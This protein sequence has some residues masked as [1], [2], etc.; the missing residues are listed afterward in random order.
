MG[1][2]VVALDCDCVNIRDINWLGKRLRH[3]VIAVANSSKRLPIFNGKIFGET[4]PT[5]KN[6]T[7]FIIVAR[8]SM[9]LA[10]NVNNIDSIR[11]VTRDKSLISSIALIT[12][13]YGIPFSAYD[14][15]C[16]LAASYNISEKKYKDEFEF[17]RV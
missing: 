11:I 4:V 13:Q 3:K 7:D 12:A 17:F 15:P 10:R 2:T 16:D 9:L 8:I 5:F 14:K 6:A 1:I